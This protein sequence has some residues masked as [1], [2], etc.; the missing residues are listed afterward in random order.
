MIRADIAELLH[1]GYG[2]RTIARRLNITTGSV[3]R[4]RTLLGLP[5]AKGG[6]KP[7]GS[8][9]DAFWQR[10][11]IRDDGHI[12]WTGNRNAKGTPTLGWSGG[13]YSALRVAYTI[14]TGH[15]PRG[16][17]FIACTHPG[18]IS[19]SHI[20]DTAVTGRPAHHRGGR[21]RK[22]NGTREEVIALLRKGLSD[23]EVARQ[24]RTNPLR[25]AK[26]RSEEGI[27]SFVRPR[28]FED[29]W[30]AHA[31][32]VDGG[33]VRWTGSSAQSTPTVWL[34]GRNHSLRPLVFRAQFGREPVG[35]V[36]PGCGVPAC[37]A[38]A[39]LE[40]R[41]MRQRTDELFEA[42]FGSAA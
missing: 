33:H 25:V 34:D 42:I 40:D 29:L 19:P 14:R 8:I 23:K 41:P 38:G 6:T 39:H 7:A 20:D 31:V 22:P 16:Y 36:L 17:A 21:G 24:L 26:V 35:P 1:A 10:V 9:E 28:T 15:P 11:S 3:T 27:P 37:V 32:P 12:D 2:D 13:H 4:A 18:C 5:K 30:A